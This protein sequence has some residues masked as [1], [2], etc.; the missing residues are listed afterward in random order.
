MA[1]STFGWRAIMNQIP[2]DRKNPRDFFDYFLGDHGHLSL[3]DDRVLARWT[4][5]S[6]VDSSLH[7]GQSV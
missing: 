7:I 2:S 4:T 1:P 3:D 5:F 6:L